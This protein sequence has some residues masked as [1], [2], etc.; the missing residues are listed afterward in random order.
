MSLSAIK[1]DPCLECIILHTI[2]DYYTKAIEAI[3][4]CQTASVTD[5]YA[6]V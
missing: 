6:A 1:T 4:Q 3:F 2:A 5:L